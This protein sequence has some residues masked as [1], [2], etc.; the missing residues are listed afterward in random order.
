MENYL[1]DVLYYAKMYG[2]F[3]G[4][5]DPDEIQIKVLDVY[6]EEVIFNNFP[7]YM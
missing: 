1:E 5:E 4:A 7:A 2:L 6:T 3:F